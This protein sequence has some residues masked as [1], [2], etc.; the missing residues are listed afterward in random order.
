MPTPDLT[1]LGKLV[2]VPFCKGPSGSTVTR[3]RYGPTTTV[4]HHRA[5]PAP[6]ETVGLRVFAPPV[7]A[8]TRRGPQGTERT[9]LVTFWSIDEWRGDDEKTGERGDDMV[10]ADGRVYHVVAVRDF[11]EAGGFY[12]ADA[13]LERRPA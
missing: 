8:S 5:R 4:N 1:K 11:F 6:T 7:K 3:R 13:Q 10:F 2:V 12:E 9:D